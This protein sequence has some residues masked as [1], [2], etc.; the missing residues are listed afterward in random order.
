MI[1][2]LGCIA[3]NT[4]ANLG[5]SE[6]DL[7]KPYLSL[8]VNDIN[9]GSKIKFK[10]DSFVV[11]KTKEIKAF[12]KAVESSNQ[13]AVDKMLLTTS[14]YAEIFKSKVGTKSRRWTEIDK[15]PYSGMGGGGGQPDAKTTAMQEHASMYAIEQGLNKNGFRDKQLFMNACGKQLEKL[16]PEMNDIWLETFF[17]QQL[18]VAK[19]VPNNTNF[20]YSRDDGFMEKITTLVKQLGISN[21]DTWNPADIWLVEDPALQMRTLVKCLTVQEINAKL[22]DMFEDNIVVGISLKKMSGKVARWELVNL[23]RNVFK[24]QPTFKR[25]AVTC[26]FNLIVNKGGVTTFQTT[27]TVF[28]INDGSSRVAKIQIRQ[29]SRGMSN[30]KFEATATSATAARMGKVPLDMLAVAMNEY[31]LLLSNKHQSYPKTTKEFKSQASKYKAMF[32]KIKPHVKTN[33]TSASEFVD[34]VEYIYSIS[35]DIA[36]SKLMQLNFLSKVVSL[37]TAKSNALATNM[38]F[39]AQKKGNVFGPFGKLY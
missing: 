35:P 1:G 24:S 14:G 31:G 33:V 27:D 3:Y 16:Y 11:E 37:N 20:K 38:Y 34:N 32:T 8:I 6:R 36:M 10:S 39:L 29:N 19:E 30:L 12:I 9:S 26:P 2:L 23:N 13:T 7:S 21:K 25:G 22:V 15:S 4:M 17:Q 18:T 28:G 5:K